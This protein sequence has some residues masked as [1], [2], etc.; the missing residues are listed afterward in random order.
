MKITFVLLSIVLLLA[1][2]AS[3]A[4]STF[5]DTSTK[6]VC[7][8][9]VSGDSLSK[10]TFGNAAIAPAIT[11]AT[12]INAAVAAQLTQL[13][14]PSA[15]VGI[16]SL[17][18]KGS[19]VPAPFDNLGPVLIDRPDTV[20][21]GNAFLSGSFQH[22]NFN[23]LDGINLK[24]LP[25]GFSYSG[26]V[27][28]SDRQV[29]FGSMVN[30]LSFALD[31][32]VGVAT[33]GVTATTDV[34]VIVPVN[35]V[36]LSVTAS[37]PSAYV[38]DVPTGSYYNL[39]PPAGSSVTSTGTASGIGDVILNVK[40]MLIGQDHNRP[41]AAAGA[42]FRF[43]T[44][45]SLNYLGSGA[46]GG[47][48]YGLAEYRARLSPHF[49]VGYEWNTSSKML[50]KL[51]SS[52]NR[53]PGGLTYAVGADYR[54]NTRL[55]VNTDIL[56]MEFINTPYF[57]V[58]SVPF[59]PAPSANSGIPSAYTMT[60]TPNSS[61]ATANFSGGLKFS[62]PRHILIYGNALVQLNNVG[63][64]SDVVPLA[65]IAYSFRRTR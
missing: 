14:I 22:F 50:D 4:Q 38:Y 48:L 39:S 64:R 31:Q 57:T 2:R 12:P 29:Y 24:A 49:M 58:E 3:L 10:A 43:A 37:R 35:S 45:D 30:N 5:C 36:S 55:T 33:V 41:A 9:P 27:G 23:A 18:R 11:A 65:G 61:Y 21:R 44:G 6:L 42:T 53:L 8:F 28:A 26:T 20:G 15:T 51:G 63:L 40:Q 47:S 46:Y 1:T 32:Y 17:R 19:E 25:V 16:V 60:S 56:G 62:L 34:S 13:P 54:I 59:S 52:V 7:E